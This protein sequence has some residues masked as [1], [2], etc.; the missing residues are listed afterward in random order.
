MQLSAP[1]ISASSPAPPVHTIRPVRRDDEINLQHFIRNLSAASRYARFMMAIR[2][3]PD[4]MLDRFIH[5]LPETELV[6]VATSPFGR[7]TALGQYAC[8]DSSGGCEV[9]VVVGDVWQR[10]GLG[11]Q[12]LR[13]VLNI[14]RD[15]G[16]THFHSQ[17][18]ADNYPMRALARKLGCEIRMNAEAAFLI[19]ISG[20]IGTPGDVRFD[21]LTSPVIAEPVAYN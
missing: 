18:L 16:F 13:A 7:I 14:A 2:E 15:N 20:T 3:L 12:L 9:A 19:Q 1:G 4:Y 11:T 5:P 10:Q 8:D 17:V 6:L 21:G